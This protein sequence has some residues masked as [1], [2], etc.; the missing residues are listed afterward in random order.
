M[1][2]KFSYGSESGSGK[3]VNLRK[4]KMMEMREYSKAK[5]KQ[6]IRPITNKY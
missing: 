5:E 2:G 1:R 6:R 4:S 3:V